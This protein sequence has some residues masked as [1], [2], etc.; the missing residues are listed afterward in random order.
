VV[1]GGDGGDALFAG[2]LTYQASLLHAATTARLPGPL[3]KLLA[4]AAAWLPVGEGKVSASYRAMRFLRAADLP[5]R[6]AHFSWNGTWRP[7]EAQELLRGEH[8]RA[9]AR[10]ALQD[11]AE[12]H[13]LPEPPDLTDLQ[14]AD[15]G[16]Y[17]PNDILAKVDRMSMAH[18]LEVRAPFLQPA[19]A[20]FALSLP[21][22]LRCGRTGRPKRL[23]R[24][25]ARALYGSAIA[26]KRKQGFSI[27][28]H[29][30]LRGPLKATAD[31]LLAPESIRAIDA[32]DAAAVARAWA[33]HLS[34]RRLLGWEVWGLMVLAAWHRVR[35]EGRPEPASTTDRLVRREIP[36]STAQPLAEAR[37]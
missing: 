16:D 20:E 9:A 17:L 7:S 31:E 35:V 24:E 12:R 2:Y 3:R 32:L 15:L 11:L 23:L 28:I 29:T 19:M 10:A 34:G 1:V 13:W 6:E 27:P 26:D 37:R 5:T 18:G 4:R 25:L 33:D 30:W 22:G 14:R 36:L 8:A 21:A